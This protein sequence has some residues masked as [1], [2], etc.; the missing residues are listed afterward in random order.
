MCP[1]LKL[2]SMSHGKHLQVVVLKEKFLNQTKSDTLVEAW[3]L[4]N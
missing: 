4:E 3:P 1:K 2:N